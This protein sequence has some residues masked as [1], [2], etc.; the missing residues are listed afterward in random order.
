MRASSILSSLV[1]CTPLLF[2]S[3]GAKHVQPNNTTGGASPTMHANIIEPS[4]QEGSSTDIAEPIALDADETDDGEELG[5]ANDTTSRIGGKY[6]DEYTGKRP[7]CP[8]ATG[9]CCCCDLDDNN[10]K[11]TEARAYNRDQCSMTPIA[12]DSHCARTCKLALRCKKK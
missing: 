8:G 11:V 12:H 9:C 4:A 7:W 5:T 1:C 3:I 10:C 2:A 6:C